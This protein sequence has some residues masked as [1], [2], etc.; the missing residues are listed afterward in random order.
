MQPEYRKSE[1]WAD[2]SRCFR[3]DAKEILRLSD[4]TVFL[5]RLRLSLSLGLLGAGVLLAFSFNLHST[6]IF[7]QLA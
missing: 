4:S 6:C 7:V 5:M 1:H 3:F 2:H